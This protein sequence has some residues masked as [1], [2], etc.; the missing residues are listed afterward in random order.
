MKR[1]VVSLSSSLE[2]GLNMYALSACAAGVGTLALAQPAEARIVYT[3]AHKYVFAKSNYW[4]FDINGDGT[5][6]FNVFIWASNE[7]GGGLGIDLYGSHRRN[8]IILSNGRVGPWCSDLPVG[9]RIGAPPTR[10]PIKRPYVSG[11]WCKMASW[12]TQTGRTLGPWGN[13]G[14]GVKDRYLGLKFH[15]KGKAHYG[16]A[17]LTSNFN[18]KHGARGL[19]LLT[20]YAYETIPNKAI[21]A[22][23][24]HGGNEATLGRLAQGASGVSNGG[25]P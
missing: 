24:T 16:W 5:P 9:A 6:D 11:S 2:R 3:P 13:Y 21:K 15:V 1:K 7:V 12:L 20:G 14:K 17:R 19:L 4:A 18:F 25:K 23:Q 22:G 8:R 10:S